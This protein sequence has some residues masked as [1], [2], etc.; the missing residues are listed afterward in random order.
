ML[1][2]KEASSLTSLLLSAPIVPGPVSVPVSDDGTDE[3]PKINWE[4]RVI[5]RPHWSLHEYNGGS[6][7]SC[8]EERKDKT[9][10]TVCSSATA[11]TEFCL[12]QS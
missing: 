11:H 9:A 6:R 10:H 3:L 5:F 8:L 7:H 12:K 4:S 2:S 1:L